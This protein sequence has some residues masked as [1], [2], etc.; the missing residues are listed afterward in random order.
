[1]A[2]EREDFM[3]YFDATESASVF[4]MFFVTSFVLFLVEFLRE[5]VSLHLIEGCP[6]APPKTKNKKI[7]YNLNIVKTS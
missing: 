7:K 3:I 5:G 6:E 2:H 4:N 1:M